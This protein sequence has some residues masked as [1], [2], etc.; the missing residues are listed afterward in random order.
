MLSNEYL[1]LSF[2]KARRD[3]IRWLE[4]YGAGAFYD[5]MLDSIQGAEGRCLHCGQPIYLDIVEGGGIPDWRTK[6]G[7]YGCV[8]SPDTNDEGTGGHDARKGD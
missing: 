5:S 7:D 1:A 2:D 4:G 8:E 6:D 3:W